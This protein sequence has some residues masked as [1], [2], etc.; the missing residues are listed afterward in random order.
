MSCWGTGEFVSEYGPADCPD[1]GGSGTL[2]SKSVLI[3]W[4]S[5]DIERAHAGADD[6]VGADVRWLAAELRNARR[7]LNEIIALAHDLDDGD[8]I[9]RRIRFIANRALGTYEPVE[10]VASP[11][12][13]RV[14]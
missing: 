2:P 10:E 3:E 14:S 13:A 11:G 1:C 4:R 8:S 6:A 7:A 9:A 5:R 12:P